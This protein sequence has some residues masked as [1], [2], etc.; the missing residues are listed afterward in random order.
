MPVDVTSVAA[1]ARRLHASRSGLTS[2]AA[3]GACG[4]AYPFGVDTATQRSTA[5]QGD[6]RWSGGSGTEVDVGRPEHRV[7]EHRVGEVGLAEVLD[8]AVEGFGGLA[9][10]WP[11]VL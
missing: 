7:G 5:R 11:A 1:E 8:G 3:A 4:G 9:G 10:V 2:R 6:T